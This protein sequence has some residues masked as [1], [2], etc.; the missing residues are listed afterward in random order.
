LGKC[1]FVQTEIDVLGV[2]LVGEQYN[3]GKKALAKLFATQLPTTLSELQSL[4]GKLNHCAP[5]VADYKRKVRPL[6]E[7]MS[8]DK[9]G[10]WR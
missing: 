10:L 4:L 1:K 6:I 9:A 8:G 2:V 3:L 5:F 7:L